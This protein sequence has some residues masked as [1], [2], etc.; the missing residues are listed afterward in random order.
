M[1]AVGVL[2]SSNK[3]NF[4]SLLHGWLFLLFIL[5]L[6]SLFGYLVF[7]FICLRV[8]RVNRNILRVLRNVLGFVADE[9]GKKIIVD[10]AR[11]RLT[12]LVLQHVAKVFKDIGLELFL[13]YV[14][15]GVLQCFLPNV[16]YRSSGFHFSV[17]LLCRKRYVICI[18]IKT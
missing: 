17:Q 13:A 1:L 9:V 11:R 5:I 3:H 4:L 10:Y 6:R 18:V 15:T 14:I 7:K 12:V 16:L 2:A 8:L